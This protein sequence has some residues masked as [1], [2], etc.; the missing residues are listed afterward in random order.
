MDNIKIY[1]RYTELCGI[2]WT[3]MV[4]DKDQQSALVETA[5]NIRVH[6]TSENYWIAAQLAASQTGFGYMESVDTV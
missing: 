4:Q 3:D 5:M 6:K 2:D 1:I